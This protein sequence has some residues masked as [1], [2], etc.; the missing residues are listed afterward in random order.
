M[1]VK[2]TFIIMAFTIALSGSLQIANAQNTSPFWSLAGNSNTTATSKLGTTN[3]KP[4][5]LVTNNQ[6]RVIID[7]TKAI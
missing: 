3:A 6:P 1:K 4:L 7:A 5:K 2:S